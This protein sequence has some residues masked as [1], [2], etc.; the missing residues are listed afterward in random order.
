MTVR[1]LCVGECMVELTH[2]DPGTLRLGFAGDTY[3]TAVYVARVA[4]ELALDA[5]VGYLTG[6]GTDDFSA[7]MRAAWLADGVLDRSLIVPD[8]IPGLYAVRTAPDGERSFTYWR[9]ES[10]ARALFADDAWCADLDADLVHLSGITM[11]LVSPTAREALVGRL[12]ELRR[13]GARVSFDTN[14]RPSGWASAHEAGAAMAQICAVADIVLASREDEEQ[15]HGRTP[16]EASIA[17]LEAL[18][19]GEVVLRDGPEGAYVSA[20]GGVRHVPPRR[21]DRVL[22]TTAAGDAFAGGY[23]AARLA[24]EPAESAAALGNAVAAAVIQQPGAITPPEIRLVEPEQ[25]RREIDVT[26]P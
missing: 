25:V 20:G 22:D 1:V 3:N 18:G 16:V 4:R 13:A 6:V 21:V 15:L 14:Y 2:L 11:Q 10:A 8:H 5:D 23:L 9:R 26:T 24:N 17:R 19:A 7:A 12:A